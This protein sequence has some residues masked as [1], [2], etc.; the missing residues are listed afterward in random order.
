MHAGAVLEPVLRRD[1]GV[2]R[3]EA[4]GG[5]EIPADIRPEVGPPLGPV[6]PQGRRL[7]GREG[8]GDA[9]LC[10]PLHVD[11]DD[12]RPG[13]AQR[14]DTAP[15]RRRDVGGG[16]LEEVALGDADRQPVDAARHRL[17][18]ALDGHGRRPRVARRLACHDLELERALGHRPRHR[19]A[20]VERRAEHADPGQA[21]AAEGRLQADDAAARRRAADRAAGVGARRGGDHSRC[22]RGRR[23]AA[24]AAWHAR[25]VVRVLARAEVRVLVGR[26]PGELVRGELGDGHR[27]GRGE[28]GNDVGVAVGDVI[29]EER[30]PIRR[31][32]AAGVD[33]VLPPDGH[34]GQRTGVAPLGKRAIDGRGLAPGALLCDAPDGAELVGGELLEVFLEHLGRRPVAPADLLGDRQAH[35]GASRDARNRSASGGSGR[36]CARSAISRPRRGPNLKA[37]PLHPPQT[38]TPSILSRTKSPSGDIV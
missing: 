4:L 6:V 16:V 38:I 5:L 2:D 14:L 33:Q 35:A 13:L 32:G 23:A 30:A 21:H 31:R 27:A 34:A 18:P 7:L 10:R 19:A 36:P 29:A 8:V 1:G 25:V 3:Q 12:P 20:V 26:P 37:C 9:E 28:P 24:R 22:Q 11:L 15:C 17:P